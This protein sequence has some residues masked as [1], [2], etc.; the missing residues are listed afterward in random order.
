MNI[1]LYSWYFFPT[2]IGGLEKYLLNLTNLLKK[3]HKVV[4]LISRENN[5]KIKNVKIYYVPTLKTKISFLGLLSQ[6][7]S[8]ALF[9]PYIIMKEK[10]EL[11]SSY[12]PTANSTLTLLISKFM[13]VPNLINIR[14]YRPDISLFRRVMGDI[15]LFF[16]N[17]IFIN[18]KDFKKRYVKQSFLPK[19]FINKKNWIFIPNGI[20]FKFWEKKSSIDDKKY[21]L[22]FVGHLKPKHRFV[23]KG[24]DVLYKALERISHEYNLKLHVV[25]LGPYE[26]ELIRREIA[27]V[28]LSYFEFHGMVKSKKKIRDFYYLS[29]IYVLPSTHEGMPNSLMEAM[30]TGLPSIA[31]N[32]GAVPELIDNNVN[33]FIFPNRN[34]M[35]LSKIILK[36]MKDT[37]LREKIGKAAKKKMRDNFS[38]DIIINDVIHKF[39]KI[40]CRKV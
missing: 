19:S 7:I 2:E 18:S 27:D 40:K 35:E 37:E 34:E 20:K 15:G 4:L 36:L 39:I 23:A 11:I 17:N 24:F 28:D 3:N 12:V 1:L 21:D 26:K 31:S 6:V 33:G 29:K 13:R 22:I 14:G 38:W 8:I 5:I 30:A 9:L 10:I 16:T 25:V 32:V